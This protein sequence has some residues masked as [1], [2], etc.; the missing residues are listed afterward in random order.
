MKITKRDIKVFLLGILTVIVMYLGYSWG[1]SMKDGGEA[2][3]Q[4]Q[5]D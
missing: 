1:Q 4:E 2:V 5:E 3:K